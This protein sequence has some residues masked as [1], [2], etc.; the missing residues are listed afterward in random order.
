MDSPRTKELG[1]QESL[2]AWLVGRRE[3]DTTP[4]GCTKGLHR[5]VQAGI[6]CSVPGSTFML[7]GGTPPGL[8]M[9]WFNPLGA[10]KRRRT[11]PSQQ[12]ILLSA[13]LAAAKAF[14]TSN[15]HFPEWVMTASPP[16]GPLRIKE[17]IASE[18]YN[19]RVIIIIG[20]AQIF[21]NEEPVTFILL[22]FLA[23]YSLRGGT[24]LALVC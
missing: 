4:S 1:A 12:S 20:V 19:E 3:A 7:Q 22:L 11:S 6:V 17:L 13:S 23:L 10:A 14:G 18:T 21:H 24:L 16:M 8:Q 9:A 15:N 5:R 2:E